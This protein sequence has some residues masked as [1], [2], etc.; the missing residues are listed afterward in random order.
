M[1][2]R[3]LSPILARKQPFRFPPGAD[4][5]VSQP[6]RQQM[7]ANRRSTIEQELVLGRDSLPNDRRTCSSSRLVP[8]GWLRCQVNAGVLWP[9]YAEEIAA[10]IL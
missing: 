6:E 3:R 4:V 10:V 5:R 1:N 9:K 7:A 8:I 2:D